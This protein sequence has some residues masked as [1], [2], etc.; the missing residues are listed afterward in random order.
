MSM[1]TF[2][3][4]NKLYLFTFVIMFCN[5]RKWKIMIYC[6]IVLYVNYPG[7]EANFV[8]VAMSSK[9]LKR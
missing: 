4:R 6:S 5:A 8:H 9:F 7:H 3:L 2:S 1:H